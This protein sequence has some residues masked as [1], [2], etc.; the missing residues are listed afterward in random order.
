M[1]GVVISINY[2]ISNWI[3]TMGFIYSA[4]PLIDPIAIACNR[5]AE[6]TMN[7]AQST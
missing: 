1:T 4:I 6:I 5:G 7:R 2:I 3:N